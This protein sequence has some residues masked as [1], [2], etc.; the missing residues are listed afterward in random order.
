MDIKNTFLHGD[1]EEEVYIKQPQGFADSKYF[2]HVYR[3]VKY[4]Y[5]LKQAHR[6]CNSKFT[7]YLLAFGFEASLSDTS[8]FVKVDDENVILLLYVSD[9]I[10]TGS[11]TTKI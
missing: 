1:L 6:A 9:T 7:S 4:L 10:F 11:S 8:L 2:N 5:G 3:W